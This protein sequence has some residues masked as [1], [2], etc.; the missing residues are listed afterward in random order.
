[1]A[2]IYRRTPKGGYSFGAGALIIPTVLVFAVILPPAFEGMGIGGFLM[3]LFL[4]GVG[5][6]CKL[7]HDWEPHKR[8]EELTRHC[9]YCWRE[10]QQA[11]REAYLDTRQ[12]ARDAQ[13]ARVQALTDAR[14]ARRSKT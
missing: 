6:G 12:A 11:Q 5:I 10:A 8:H 4:V 2:R 7:L 9:L 1:M 3:L 14:R 13:H